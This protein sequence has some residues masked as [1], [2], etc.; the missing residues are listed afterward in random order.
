MPASPGVDLAGPTLLLLA[1]VP[2]LTAAVAA[3][4]WRV[5]AG[6]GGDAAPFFAAMGLFLLSDLGIAISLSDDRAGALRA[7]ASRIVRKHPVLLVDRNAASAPVTLMYT[8]W[9][10]W[11][12]RGKLQAGAEYH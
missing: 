1:P 4:V 9:S 12:F 6:W 7:L 8:A 5:L 2:V 10:Y 3:A 11:V